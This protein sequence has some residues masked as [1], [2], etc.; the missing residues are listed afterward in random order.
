MPTSVLLEEPYLRLHRQL[1]P[2]LRVSAYCIPLG[3]PCPRL[4]QDGEMPTS[5]EV[6]IACRRA[7]R[8]FYLQERAKPTLARHKE[9][10]TTLSSS[11]RK[12][13]SPR[14]TSSSMGGHTH[15]SRPAKGG[16]QAYASSLVSGRADTTPPLSLQEGAK[17]TTPLQLQHGVK[18]AASLQL[19]DRAKP[20]PSFRLWGSASSKP[21]PR[22]AFRF[23]RG[24][25]PTPP[26]QLQ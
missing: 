17:R 1:S 13:P 19:Q 9:A 8:L 4:S 24:P 10:K 23:R 20:T 12:G 21:Y 22:S 18:A 5:P 14:L 3:K 16:R 26:L 25:E 15:S 2:V 6:T 11:P 7:S